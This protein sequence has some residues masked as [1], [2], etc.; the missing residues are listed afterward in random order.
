MNSEFMKTILLTGLLLAISCSTDSDISNQPIEN[1]I[2]EYQLSVIDSFGVEFGDSINMIGNIEGFC[3][4]PSGSV[5]LLDRTAMRIRV[6]PEDGEAFCCGREGEGPGEFLVPLGICAMK[7]GRIL[8]ADSWRYEIMEFDLSGNYSGSYLNAGEASIPFEIYQVDS[9]SIVGSRLEVDL[10]SD[11]MQYLF[12]IGRFDS[13][14]NPNVKYEELCIELTSADIY[15]DIEMVDFFATPTGKVFIVPDYTEYIIEVFSSDGIFECVIDQE[16]ER[17]QKSEEEIQLEIEEFEQAVSNNQVY[18]GVQGYQPAQYHQLISLAGV[19]ADGKLW[20]ERCDSEDG[21]SF[22]VWDLTGN[23][24]YTVI[25][26]DIEDNLDL[27]FHVDQYGILG[28]NVDSDQYPRIYT[29]KLD[30]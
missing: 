7:D 24:T 1:T 21:Y 3:Y 16:I 11:P 22:D 9:N 19:D 14:C 17:M 23:L 20:V 25:L 30:N 6:I 10:N 18:I 5:L 26:Q 2:P 4:H 8:I 28:A 13:N 12:Y 27:T 29:F 15:R